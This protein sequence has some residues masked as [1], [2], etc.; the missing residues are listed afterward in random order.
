MFYMNMRAFN[1][2]EQADK[3]R[4]KRMAN[5][6]SKDNDESSRAERRHYKSLGDPDYENAKSQYDHQNRKDNITDK[7][8]AID[9]IKRHNR[10]HENLKEDCGIFESVEII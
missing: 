3:Y 1:E 5:T 8:N 7:M 10:R 4:E 6:I 9:G 2:G